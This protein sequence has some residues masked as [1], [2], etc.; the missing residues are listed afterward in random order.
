MTA[1][2]S[3][4]VAIFFTLYSLIPVT[5]AD[6]PGLSSVFVG[7]MMAFVMGVQVFTPALVRRLSLRYVLTGSA[8]LLA[9]GALVTGMAAATPTLLIGA[10]ATG[11]GFGVLIVAGAQGVA[12]LVPPTKLGR[13]L[14]TYGLFTMAASAL[15]SPAGVQLALT[16]SSPVFGICAFAAGII[17]A[18]LSFGIPAGVGRTPSGPS[19]DN[20]DNSGESG[21]ST[22]NAQASSGTER[23]PRTR[24]SLVAN[25]P[26]LVLSLLLAAVVVLSHGLSSLPVL[27]SAYGRAAVVVF[28]VQ[29]GNALGRGIGGELEAKVEAGGAATTGAVLLAAGGVVGVLV[30]GSAAVIAS[31]LL[32]GLGVGIVQ[33]V[34]LHVAMRRLDSGPA[35]V[36]WNLSVDGGLWVGGILWGVALTAGLLT[37]GV[38]AVSAAA[39]IIG[40]GVTAQLRR[41]A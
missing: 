6:A 7:T 5:R 27:A 21:E 32:I 29:A 26:W 12:L 13:A 4:S 34:T 38:L 9:A 2:V 14:G 11:A 24:P 25:A 33:T 31:G 41:R 3:V 36:V 16:F 19:V 17:A 39:I 1:T 15:G 20:V 37:A 40:A 10:V 28:A 35:S 30:G 18:G 8:L 22:T 23:K